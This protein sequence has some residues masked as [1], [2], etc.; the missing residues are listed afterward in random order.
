MS[1]IFALTWWN[2]PRMCTHN[3]DNEWYIYLCNKDT[4]SQSLPP[5]WWNDPRM[6]THN[7]DNEWYIY[8]CN[9]D[10]MSQIFALTW[11]NDPRMC[12]HNKDNEWYI[13][14]CNKDTMSQS[15]PPPGGMTHT[16]LCYKPKVSYTWCRSSLTISIRVTIQRSQASIPAGTRLTLFIGFRWRLSVFT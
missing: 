2:D 12:T 3:K 5:T 15:L 7:K 13:Y 16:Y 8:L 4:M 10:T 9:K 11:W 6:C 1:Q 14:L